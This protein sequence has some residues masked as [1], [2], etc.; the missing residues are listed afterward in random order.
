MFFFCFPPR[1]VSAQRV[2]GVCILGCAGET[3]WSRPRQGGFKGIWWLQLHDRRG[4]TVPVSYCADCKGMIVCL[5][6]C[7]Q[8]SK[9][10]WWFTQVH[11]SA[12][13]SPILCG[14]IAICPVTIFKSSASLR[15]HRWCFMSCHPRPH[16][17]DNKYTRPGLVIPFNEAS[18][19]ALEVFQ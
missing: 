4:G 16:T 8:S 10:K 15:S 11:P 12:L 13:V 14:M 7:T 19:K 6:I 3:S 9:F 2:K 17:M 1:G 5:S 18:C